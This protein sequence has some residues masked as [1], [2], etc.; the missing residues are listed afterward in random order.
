MKIFNPF[1]LKT[2][3]IILGPPGAGKSTQAN[4]L[5]DK[6]NFYHL[7][8][9]RVIKNRINTAPRND[10]ILINKKKYFFRDEKKLFDAGLLCSPPFVVYLLKEKIKK[11]SEEGQ[12]IVFSGS[13]R[14]LY[15]AKELIPFLSKLYSRSHIKIIDISLSSTKAIW[16]NS[17]RRIC[18]L[19]G[20]SIIWNSETKSLSH[21]PLDGSK[22]IRRPLDKPEVIKVRLHE[23]KKKILPIR[24][25]LRETG[26]SI[27]KINGDQTVNLVFQDIL[28]AI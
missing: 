21:C 18:S 19:V 16:R 10:F 12:G 9:S 15:E 11:V 17:H 25:Y 20:H 1:K 14:T 6:F 28:K 4:L 5:N 13:P 7:E 3:V 26:F 2:A 23:F 8:T 24:K 27:K 22:L